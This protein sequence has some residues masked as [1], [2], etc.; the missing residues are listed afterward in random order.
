MAGVHFGRAAWAAGLLPIIAVNAAYLINLGAGMDGCFPYLEG[1]QSVSQGVRSGPGLWLFKS[2]ALP[3]AVA[4]TLAWL[5][6]GRWLD[7][8]GLGSPV[9]RRLVVGLGWVGAAFFLVYA[10]WLGTEGDVYRWL[11]RYGVVF[12]FAGT[13][14]AQLFLLSLVWS[15]RQTLRGG[16]FQPVIVRLAALVTLVWGLGVASAF[17]R[18]LI[19]DPGFLDRVENALEWDFALALSLTFLGLAPLCGRSNRSG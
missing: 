18:K 16:V 14:L 6:I 11:R 17:K 10:T 7:T 2:L 12:Y 9:R 1:C 19:D 5:G 15:E 13:G 3:G 8:V 4:M